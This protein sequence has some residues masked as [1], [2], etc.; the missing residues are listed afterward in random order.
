MGKRGGGRGAG[1]E[2]RGRGAGEEG[3]LQMD[4]TKHS[5]RWCGMLF[6]NVTLQQ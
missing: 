3:G 4:I 2:G 5:K 6:P 1:E